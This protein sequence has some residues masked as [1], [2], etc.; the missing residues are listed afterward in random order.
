T[1]AMCAIWIVCSRL[2]I[3][4]GM[5]W[6]TSVGEIE[7]CVGN[8]WLPRLQRLARNTWAPGIRGVGRGVPETQQ[9]P[10]ATRPGSNHISTVFQSVVG[11]LNRE[12]GRTPTVA[13]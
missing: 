6:T 2:P 7:T 12:L 13:L 10:H 4:C 3:Q 5:Y 1:D 11:I 8:R 9:P